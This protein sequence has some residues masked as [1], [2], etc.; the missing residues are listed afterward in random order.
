MIFLLYKEGVVTGVP[1]AP[2]EDKWCEFKV[3]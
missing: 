2:V 1:R 3:V